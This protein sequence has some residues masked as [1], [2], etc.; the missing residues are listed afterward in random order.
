MACAAYG[1]PWL[2]DGDDGADAANHAAAGATAGHEKRVVA[3]EAAKT[4]TEMGSSDI[5]A[6]EASDDV[7][8]L[9]PL[10][11]RASEAMAKAHRVLC[12]AFQR[13]D[14]KAVCP[15]GHRLRVKEAS[16]A[17]VRLCLNCGSRLSCT[18]V[19]CEDG[20]FSACIRCTLQVAAAP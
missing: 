13:A 14:K 2:A 1:S 7:R 18:H 16:G 17:M 9:G 10:P 4:W 6:A 19:T 8:S 20:H 3:E 15:G 5:A 12:S 11:A